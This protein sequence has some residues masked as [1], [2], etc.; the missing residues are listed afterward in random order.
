MLEKVCVRAF[1]LAVKFHESTY[2]V[3]SVKR[4]KNKNGSS[5]KAILEAPNLFFFHTGHETYSFPC[6]FTYILRTCKSFLSP[7]PYDEDV[8]VAQLQ[9][10]KFDTCEPLVAVFV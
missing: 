8:L 9:I 2:V 6:K 10:L 3:S 1:D 4:K 5:R 7:C